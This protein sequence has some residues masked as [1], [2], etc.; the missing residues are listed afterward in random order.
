[1]MLYAI[2]AHSNNA[3]NSTDQ[4]QHLDYR[5]SNGEQNAKQIS[6]LIS[7]KEK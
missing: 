7:I 3:S 5:L 2:A 6:L 4:Y 1:M